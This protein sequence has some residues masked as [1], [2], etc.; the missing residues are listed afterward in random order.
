MDDIFLRYI[1]L[2]HNVKGLTVQDEEGRYN[3]YLNARLT[4]EAHIE[5]IQHEIEHIDN[6]DFSRLEH[7]KDI[8]K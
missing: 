4:R 2:P 5:T 1:R 7:V 6:N 3:I 8:E